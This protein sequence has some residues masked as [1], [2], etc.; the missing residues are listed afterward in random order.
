MKLNEIYSEYLSKLETALNEENYDNIDYI[1]EFL[2]IPNIEEDVYN[3]ISDII[4]EA[5]LFSELKD[6]EYKDQALELISEYK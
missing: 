1:L 5:T 6:A 3:E 4:D 2:N